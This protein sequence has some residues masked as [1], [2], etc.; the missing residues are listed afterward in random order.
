MSEEG[1]HHS[2]ALLHF[3][4]LTYLRWQEPSH[5]IEQNRKQLHTCPGFTSH[6]AFLLPLYEVR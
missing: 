6:G 3:T 4:V 5:P 1:I 2:K